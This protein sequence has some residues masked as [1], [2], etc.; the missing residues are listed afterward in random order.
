MKAMVP[1]YVRISRL[2]RDIPGE[3]IVAGCR[4]SALRGTLGRLM[5]D[6][7]LTC[8]CTR[9]REFGHRTLNGISIG[10]PH[11]MRLDYEAS[12]G[13][14]IFLSFEDTR[15][16]LYGL[17]RLRIET[18]L[19]EAPGKVREIHVFG[20]EVPI[21]EKDKEAAQHRGWGELLVRESERITYSEFGRKRLSVLAGVGARQYFSQLGYR[22]EGTYML[23]D[24]TVSQPSLLSAD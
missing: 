13:R 5:I 12:G 20:P 22:L 10:T 8:H 4:D 1:P 23:R 17:L 6:E 11:L 2:M 19:P 3:F 21:G 18:A 15:Q 24:L 7:N 16:T 14:E 9:C